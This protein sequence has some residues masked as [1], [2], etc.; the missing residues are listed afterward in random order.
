[1]QYADA[2]IADESFDWFNRFTYTDGHLISR[3]PVGTFIE[4]E[5]SNERRVFIYVYKSADG[6]ILWNEW[7]FSTNYAVT[8]E[9][10][11]H[12]IEQIQDKWLELASL[13]AA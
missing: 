5:I 7:D 9:H 2:E 4:E 3:V 1:M 13:F 10:T 6:Y 8:P 11:Q 12:V